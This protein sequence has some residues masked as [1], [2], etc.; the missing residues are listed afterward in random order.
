MEAFNLFIPGNDLDSSIPCAFFDWN[1]C[2]T[3][4]QTIDYTLAFS[5][6]NAFPEATCNRGIQENGITAIR[7]SSETI[8]PDSPLFGDLV[9]ATDSADAWYQEYWFRGAWF[10][11]VTTFW[12]EFSSPRKNAKPS[13]R[14]VDSNSRASKRTGYVHLNGRPAP[15]PG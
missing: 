10:D 5:C 7:M 14:T 4:D 9:V 3:T 6:G 12:R 8:P 13:L 11:D 15:C 2:N 1:I